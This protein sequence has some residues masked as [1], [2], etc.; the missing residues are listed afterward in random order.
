MKQDSVHKSSYGSRQ[1]Q[2]CVI[3]AVKEGTGGT[4]HTVDNEIMSELGLVNA[5]KIRIKILTRFQG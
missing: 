2:R 1:E 4:G 5:K 3:D